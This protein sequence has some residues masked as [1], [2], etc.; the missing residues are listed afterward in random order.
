VFEKILNRKMFNK[1]YRN[2]LVAGLGKLTGS[3]MLGKKGNKDSSSSTILTMLGLTLT[4][5]TQM[6]L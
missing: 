5:C 3:V 1:G 4:S 6:F 2:L